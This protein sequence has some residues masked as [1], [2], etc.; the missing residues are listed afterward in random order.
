MEEVVLEL[1]GS[2]NEDSESSGSEDDF[3]GYLNEDSDGEEDDHGSD[4]DSSSEET[5]SD[6]DMQVEVPSVPSYTLQVG[7]SATL[8]GTRPLDYF[9]L[10]MDDAM[11]QHIV[12]QTNLCAQQYMESHTLAPHSRKRQWQKEEHTLEELQRSCTDPGDGPGSLSQGRESLEHFL[13]LCHRHF[14]KCTFH[15]L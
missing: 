10:F 2:D 11:L 9:S 7:V 12:A 6:Q 1:D 14:L 5:G 8:S 3:E 13:A 4:D 15:A